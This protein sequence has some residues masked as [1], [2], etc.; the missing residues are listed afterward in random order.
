MPG[1][2]NAQF[3]GINNQG[4]IVGSYNTGLSEITRSGF[5][6]RNGAYT[7]INIPG[8]YSTNL[9]AINN[10]GDIVGIYESLT[11]GWH[12]FLLHDGQFID[13]NM[14]YGSHTMPF[15]DK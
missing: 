15:G 5:L 12:G 9:Y 3:E 13:V 7:T 10:L 1:H 2:P 6:L 14:P 4:D 8:A 11:T